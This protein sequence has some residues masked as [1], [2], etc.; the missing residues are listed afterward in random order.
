MGRLS[1]LLGVLVVAI[2]AATLVRAEL[3]GSLPLPPVFES[4]TAICEDLDQKGW[5]ATPELTEALAGRLTT[6]FADLPAPGLDPTTEAK[7]LVIIMARG[8][9]LG[10][11]CVRQVEIY[12]ASLIATKVFPDQPLP[13]TTSRILAEIERAKGARDALA[14]SQTSPRA[15]RLFA[16]PTQYPPGD[17]AAYAILVFRSLATSFDRDRHQL[18]CE[19]FV[20]GLPAARDLSR[21]LGV[22]FSDQI[23]TVW[24]VSE[25]AVADELNK[26][27]RD[28]CMSALDEYDLVAAR[29]ALSDA[30]LVGVS[31]RGRGPFLI[32]WSPA[33]SKGRPD[34]VVLQADLS[35]VETIEQ[36]NAVFR[37]WVNEIERTPELWSD[38]WDI[39]SVRVTIRN[40]LDQYG[41]EVLELFGGK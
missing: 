16:G 6:L 17:F 30:A 5:L 23:V 22:P 15:S 9:D 29:K 25:D 40:W 33:R 21:G 31:F 2:S 20:S 38:G 19:A 3:P 24:P 10:S 28:L 18:I 13:A 7:E 27:R 14:Y 36:A 11:V 37:G 39:A 35:H 1:G 4:A 41:D 8:A 26:R 12:A 32:A 34:A